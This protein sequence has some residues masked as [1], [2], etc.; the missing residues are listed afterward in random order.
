MWK[1]Y[2]TKQV[3][4]H[5]Y[6]DYF[7]GLET[8]FLIQTKFTLQPFKTTN[9][10]FEHQKIIKRLP[11]D[12]QR[13]SMIFELMDWN[14]WNKVL[15][16]NPK[17]PII[18]THFDYPFLLPINKRLEIFQQLHV[19]LRWSLCCLDGDLLFPKWTLQRNI[20]RK[21]KWN[22][23]L[24]LHILMNKNEFI[25]NQFHFQFQLKMN[26]KYF[27]P[28]LC[29]LIHLCKTVEPRLKAL[30]LPDN[31][32]MSKIVFDFWTTS[33]IPNIFPIDMQV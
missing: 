7:F 28:L 1:I 4:N 25:N 32:W 12:N 15:G 2:K 10:L 13:I 8:V 27:S 21:N 6:S 29:S 26:K 18:R 14:W 31:R 5:F 9:R 24:P 16:Q 17:L 19:R 30:T 33:I 11:K 20:P 3:S 23:Q 22:F